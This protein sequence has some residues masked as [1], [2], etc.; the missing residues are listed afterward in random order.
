MDRKISIIFIPFFLLITVP[1]LLAWAMSSQGFVFG[2]FLFNPI[3]GNSYLAKMVEGWR[4]EWAFTLPYTAQKGTGAPIFL[5][6]IFL[7][8][9]SRVTSIPIIWVFHITRIIG[10]GILVREL[11]R[12]NSVFFPT[13]TGYL[14][15]ATGL[16]LLGSGLGWMLL[17]FGIISS[18]L[19]V[20]EGFP[21]LSS[22]SSPHFTL[23][24]A[25]LVRIF[26]DLTLQE[27]PGKFIRL[28]I[29]GFLISLIMPFGMVIASLVAG[30]WIA[31][32]WKFTKQLYWRSLIALASLGGFYLAYQYWVIYH[33]PLL[34]QW[35]AQNQTPAPAGWDLFLSFS[36]A[37]LLAGWGVWKWLRNHE[38]GPSQRLVL[39][40]FLS[41]LALVYFP[42]SL[43][44]RFIFGLF[45]P[46]SILTVAGIQAFTSW[47]IQWAKKFTPFFWISSLLTNGVVILLA[48]FGIF[49]H[50]PLFFVTQDEAEGLRFIRDS[51]PAD[52]LILCSP[53][54]GLFIPAWTGRRV[55]Y[56]HEFETVDA[57]A[58]K[59]LAE[60]LLIGQM[61][62][63]QEVNLMKENF[64]QYVFLGPRERRI[65]K[66][67]F[68]SV[69]KPVFQNE[70]VTIFSW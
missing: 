70:S 11:V 44:R 30:L 24:M 46:I 5:F 53:E 23:G 66:P 59:E 16:A 4:G 33:D 40:W 50:S 2:G 1:Y 39:I 27:T 42:Y 37:I 17:L 18:D 48:L 51:L 55:L 34:S 10:A 61:G 58:K 41:G 31:V 32:E 57:K 49:S 35:N 3:D 67:V 47:K 14:R 56:G 19:W 22:F 15:K 12:F 68:Q 62:D 43:Q 64:V 6:Y 26:S 21:F 9:F 63:A 25:L 8:H 13:S 7:G 60:S 52:A 54:T 36:P 29:W 38:T 45:I 69:M 20:A 65:G 28:I